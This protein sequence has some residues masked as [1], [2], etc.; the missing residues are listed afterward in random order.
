MVISSRR[1]IFFQ[2]R[3]MYHDRRG[4]ARE[5]G[6]WYVSMLFPHLIWHYK[7]HTLYYFLSVTTG[8]LFLCRE[9]KSWRAAIFESYGLLTLFTRLIWSH[10]SNLHLP[11]K[12]SLTFARADQ[13]SGD[14]YINYKYTCSRDIH[15]SNFCH[16]LSFTRGCRAGWSLFHLS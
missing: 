4:P 13:Q 10:C 11:Y 6:F 9:V 14:I 8:T 3:A 7:Q 5:G 16:C 15:Q 12:C 1:Q 2:S